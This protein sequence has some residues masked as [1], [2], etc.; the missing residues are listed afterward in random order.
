MYTHYTIQIQ[1]LRSF[2]ELF[3]FDQ[4]KRMPNVI[5]HF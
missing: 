2:P 5:C 3:P 4:A 1:S